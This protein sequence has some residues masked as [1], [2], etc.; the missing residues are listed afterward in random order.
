MPAWQLLEWW[1]VYEEEPFGDA[2]EDLRAWAHAIMS[3]GGRG[4][5]LVWPYVEPEMTVDEV[6]SE[7]DRLE[8]AIAKNESL[9][10]GHQSNGEYP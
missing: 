9:H 2:R 3:M 5:Q 10:R 8:A 6:A 1:L 7:I 4:L